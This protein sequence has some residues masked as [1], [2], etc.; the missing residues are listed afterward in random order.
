MAVFVLKTLNG[1]GGNGYVMQLST[2][3]AFVQL[4]AGGGG[5]F[6]VQPS[7]DKAATAPAADPSPSAGNQADWAEVIDGGFPIA[8]GSADAAYRTGQSR[9]T[10]VTVRVWCKVSGTLLAIAQ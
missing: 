10:T 1:V 4:I 8:V 6:M 2:Q 7:Q 9:L 3:R 5:D